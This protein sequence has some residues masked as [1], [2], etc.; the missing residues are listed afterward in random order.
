MGAGV[1]ALFARRKGSVRAAD[2]EG[3][4]QDFKLGREATGQ[5]AVNLQLN[6]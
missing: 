2:A 4:G 6:D 5:F 3:A 1:R